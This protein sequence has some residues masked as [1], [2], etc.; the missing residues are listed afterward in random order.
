MESD[1]ECVYPRPEITDWCLRSLPLTPRMARPQIG[2]YPRSRFSRSEAESKKVF[3]VTL[4]VLRVNNIPENKF[5]RLDSMRHRSETFEVNSTRPPSKICRKLMWR[6]ILLWTK[7]ARSTWKD[8]GRNDARNQL[9][10]GA[11]SILDFEYVAS[12]DVLAE[13]FSSPFVNSLLESIKDAGIARRRRRSNR[14]RQIGS[15]KREWIGN[16]YEVGVS[17][18]P[19]PFSCVLRASI[20]WVKGFLGC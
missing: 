13:K 9:A 20:F 4:T 2:R 5:D 1:V 19:Y 10:K 11:N 17:K 12:R 8:G 7:L 3:L 16:F 18:M 14:K 15:D 6:L